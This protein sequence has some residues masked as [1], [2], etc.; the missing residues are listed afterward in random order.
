MQ[1]TPVDAI[2]IGIDPIAL[3][4][5]SNCVSFCENR[6]FFRKKPHTRDTQGD[7]AANQYELPL[8]WRQPAPVG[9]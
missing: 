7:G 8:D 2:P 5:C 6:M 4:P 3:T 9:R 1:K